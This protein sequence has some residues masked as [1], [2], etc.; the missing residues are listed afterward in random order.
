MKDQFQILHRPA[1]HHLAAAHLQ[2]RHPLR[3]LAAI[4][5]QH[6]FHLL[7]TTGPFAPVT[8]CG[9]LRLQ[10]V[11]GE[12]RATP[13]IDSHH[14]ARTDTAALD[15]AF[16]RHDNHAGFRPGNDQTVIGHDIAHRTQAVPVKA[17][18]DPVIGIGSNRRRAIPGFH[19]RIA[20]GVEL[21]EIIITANIDG[22]RNHH[23]LHHRERASAMAHKLEDGIKGCGIRAALAN[24]RLQVLDGIAEDIGGHPVFMAGHPVLVATDGVD[25]T[26]MRQH[27][28]RLRQLPGWHGVGRIALVIDGE[29]RHE[30]RVQ[31]VR[32]EGC[33][34]LGKEHPLVDDRAARHR[35]DVEI[36]DQL[37]RH[38]LF[39]AAAHDIELA[40][41]F[42]LIDIG[43]HR[44][45]DLLDFRTGGVRLVTKGVRVDRNLPPAIDHV[46]HRQNFL[47]DDTAAALLRGKIGTRQEH[48][49]DGKAAPIIIMA[50]AGDMLDEEVARNLDMDTRAITGHSVGIDSPTVPDGLKR[51]DS[52]IDHS[53]GRLAITGGDKTDTTGIMFHFRAVDAGIGQPGLIAGTAG[54]IMGLVEALFHHDDSPLWLWLRFRRRQL[55]RAALHS[56]P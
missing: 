2:R 32:E 49:A 28:K 56:A 14:L 1:S 22:G 24:H 9:K 42:F 30:T 26:I 8:L 52:G 3:A 13:Q 18:N 43:R 51:L 45:H 48:H 55:R 21:G 31:Q 47:L 19:H 46:T 10:L 12:H 15:D 37:C 35:A 16:L 36:G 29:G 41:G 40:L 7:G 17:G 5:G 25:L 33:H 38:R 34:L 50:G 27:T 54:E 44:E 20:I 39:D 23:R 53:A 11:I 4:A 6:S